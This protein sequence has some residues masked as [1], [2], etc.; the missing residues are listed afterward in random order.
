MSESRIFRLRVVMPDRPGSLGVIATR[1]GAL[2]GD[3]TGFEIL[4]RNDTGVL[5]EFVVTF[6]A[7]VPEELIKRE[8]AEEDSMVVQS[9]IEIERVLP[10]KQ[11]VTH[12]EKSLIKS[13]GR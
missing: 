12:V 4:D 1:L 8:I 10:R 3:I 6:P 9:L 11:R 13:T 7:D 5:D 2:R